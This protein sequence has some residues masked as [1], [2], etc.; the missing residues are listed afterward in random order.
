MQAKARKI[1]GLRRGS[2]VES[3]ENSFNCI[4]QAGANPAPAATFIESLEATM[5]EA[6]NHQSTL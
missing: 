6:S 1:Q 4:Q 2:G 5:L 3:R